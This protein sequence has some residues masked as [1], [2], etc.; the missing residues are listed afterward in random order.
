MS[1]LAKRIQHAIAWRSRRAVSEM[2]V[3]YRTFRI[4]KASKHEQQ[5][6][7]P[8]IAYPCYKSMDE[9]IDVLR[10]KS[11]NESI[12][13]KVKAYLRAGH[14]ENFHTGILKRKILAPSRPGSIVIPLS[15]SKSGFEYFD[16]DKPEQWQ[17]S[18]FAND[19][20]DLMDFIATLPF[21]T[22][23]R[24]MIMADDKGKAVTAHRDHSRKDVKHEFVWFRTNLDKP[25]YMEDGKS[26]QKVYVESYSAWF[27]TV[28]QFHG[29]DKTG[30]LAISIRVDGHFSDE[31]RAKVP[32]PE[33]NP[34]STAALWACLSS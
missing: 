33:C 9:Y 10:L 28:N 3:A 7:D 11:L 21:K 31:F 23:A 8:R 4:A 20:A 13:R 2:R 26:K 14:G 6:V 30:K 16:L 29:S 18:E 5:E 32:T 34:A 15:V 12:T 22:T 1:T 17:P 27:D 25:F 24:M 19:F